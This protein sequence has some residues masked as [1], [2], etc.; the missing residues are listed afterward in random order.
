M[1]AVCLSSALIKRASVIPGKAL[2]TDMSKAFSAIVGSKAGGSSGVKPEG[3]TKLLVLFE[4]NTL[5]M[6]K[7]VELNISLA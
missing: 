4:L 2:L 7:L 1:N 3:Q 6:S 5:E